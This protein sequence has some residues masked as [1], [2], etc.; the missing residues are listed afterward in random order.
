M[1]SVTIC[2]YNRASRLKE[3][4]KSLAAMSVPADLR[5]ELIVIDNNSKDDTRAVVEDLAKTSGLPVKYIFE[6]NQGL[7][8]A[9]NAGIKAARGEIIAFTD[10]DVTVDS[11]WLGHL[12][13][14]FDQF[15]CIG[16]AGKIVPVWTCKKPPWLESDG[17]TPLMSGVILSFD[18]GEE[19][20]DINTPSFGANMAFRKIAFEK[21]G[22]FRTDLDRSGNSLLS[23]GDTE[24]GRRLLQGQ[25]RLIYVPQAIIYHPVEQHRIEKRYFQSWYFGYGRSSMRRTGISAN[26]ARCFGIPTYLFRSLLANFLHWVFTLSSQRRFYYK[27]ELYRVA[28]EITESLSMARQGKEDTSCVS[29]R[30]SGGH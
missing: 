15:D 21:Y 23:G 17:P 8:H 24:F 30:E 11:Y 18:L 10:D 29:P 16:V 19:L 27:L 9:R 26:A 2:T 25:E 28:G 12:K 14:I 20:R 6:A 5:W 22:L 4:L 13:H 7:C 1:I 3:A